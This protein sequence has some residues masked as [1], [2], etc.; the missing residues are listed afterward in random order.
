MKAIEV[1]TADER[2]VLTALGREWLA[3]IGRLMSQ[4]G[5]YSAVFS[6]F[7]DS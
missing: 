1:A 3:L 7:A 4:G 6:K 2:S 5:L